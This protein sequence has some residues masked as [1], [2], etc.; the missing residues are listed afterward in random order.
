[1]I[2]ILFPSM[3]STR[4]ATLVV[5]LSE[6]FAK[7]FNIFLKNPLFQRV[8]RKREAGRVLSKVGRAHPLGFA[9]QIQERSTS[10][11]SLTFVVQA[12]SVLP[13][14]SCPDGPPQG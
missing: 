1:L 9:V 6:S 11:P 3:F 13:Q 2:S 12:E 7:K 14:T 4:K 5:P 8:R 10:A